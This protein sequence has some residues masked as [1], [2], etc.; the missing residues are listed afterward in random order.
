[1]SGGGLDTLVAGGEVETGVEVSR[2]TTYKLGGPARYFAAVST[3]RGIERLAA[4]V[5]A[6]RLPVLVLGR[7][8]NLVVSD[9][10]FDGLVMQLGGEFAAI[11]I[12]EGVVEAGAAVGLPQLA[13]QTVKAGWGGLEWCVGVPGSVGGAVAMNAGCFGTETA[14]VL[15]HATILDLRT[16][17]SFE[18]GPAA[19]EMSYRSTNLAGH[20][21][22]LGG[23]FRVERIDPGA[24]EREM[25]EITRW[26]RDHQPGGTYNAGSVF[27]NPPGD[28]AGRII[29]AAGLKGMR[30][31]D[32][33]VS[34]RHANFF[35]AG[36]AA[37]A[38]DVYD[39]VQAVKAEVAAMTGIT[40]EPEV[41]FAGRFG[42]EEEPCP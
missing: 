37:T 26:R 13:R 41:R 30:R 19:L 3:R 39:L 1:M 4:A 40:L 11:E 32:V 17:R 24:G 42:R 22:V 25:R 14:D 12:G 36:P 21:V 7:G 34:E 8:S 29:D 10:G 28:A 15:V 31:G 35:V 23:V 9:S 16:G 33:S 27:K 20:H 18:A 5:A 2:L 6:D 38:Q